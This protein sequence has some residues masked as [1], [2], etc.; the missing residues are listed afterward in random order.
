MQDTM[1]ATT[2]MPGPREPLA[3]S[4]VKPMGM[5]GL[6]FINLLLTLITFGIYRFWATTE[7]R[8]RIWS[9]IRL[10]GEPLEYTGTGKELFLGFLFVLFAVMLPAG[11]A[12]VVAVL[13]AQY[14]LGEFGGLAVI[15]LVYVGLIMVIG[16]AL[17]SAMRYRLSRTRW[18]GIRGS[19]VGS[20]WGYGWT[21]FWT[22]LLSIVSLGWT[23]PWQSAK[24]QNQLMNEARFGD[25][26]FVSTARSGPLY[27]PFAVLWIGSVLAFAGYMASIFIIMGPLIAEQQATGVPPEPTI[28]QLIPIYIAAFLFVVVVSLLSTWFYA[29]MINHFASETRFEGAT[30]RADVSAGGLIWIGLTNALIVIL[31]LGILSPVALARSVGYLVRNM[32]IDGAVPVAAILQS[33]AKLPGYGEGLGQAFDVDAF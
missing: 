15:L 5:A 8:K 6:G 32:A 10:N 13:A 16:V 14:L 29:R 31:T 27:G 3:L 17:Y 22:F 26:P 33:K 20:A 9:G 19:L 7:V 1:Y 21:Y 25:R 12:I 23:I 18:R 2:P 11:L 4:W 30:F 24:L 28:E